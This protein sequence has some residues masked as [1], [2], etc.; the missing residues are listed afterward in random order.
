MIKVHRHYKRVKSI[1]YLNLGD[2]TIPWKKR[3]LQLCRGLSWFAFFF[4]RWDFIKILRGK[5]LK[6][7]DSRLPFCCV[8]GEKPCY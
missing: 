3:F 6:K 4:L 2:E 8:V 7:T 5:I 1:D